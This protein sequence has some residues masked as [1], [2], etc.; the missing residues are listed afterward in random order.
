MN[1]P[2]SSLPSTLPLSRAA[3]LRAGA[4]PSVLLLTVVAPGVV[5][6][7]AVVSDVVVDTRVYSVCS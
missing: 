3:S 2:A 5:N 7:A 6:Q 4:P 1:R